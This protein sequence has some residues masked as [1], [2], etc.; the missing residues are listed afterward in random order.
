MP[1]DR[2]RGMIQLS[3]TERA[4]LMKVA[5]HPNTRQPLEASAT[6]PDKATCPHCEGW[7]HLRRRRLMNDGGYAYFWRHGDNKDKACIGRRK[8]PGR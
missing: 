7:V 5:R 4:I 1:N 3:S 8:L 2:K 6:A